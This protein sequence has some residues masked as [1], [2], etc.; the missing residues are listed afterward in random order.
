MDTKLIVRYAI[1]ETM[2][3]VIMGIA[4]FWS[5]GQIN[6]WPAWASLAVMFIWTVATAVVIVRSNPAL[7]VER[8]GPRKGAKAWDT[9][10]LS[11]LGVAQLVRYVTAGLDQRY[12]WT[13]GFPFVA[14]FAALAACVLGYALVVWATASNAFFS[15]IVRIQ[16]E[17][18]H[19]V[20]TGGP[21]R[22]VR[23]PAYVG[24]IVYELAVSILLASWS[25]FIISILS[26]ILLILRTILEDRVLLTE[27]NGYK[28]YARRVRFRLFPGL[29]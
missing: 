8:L 14:Q 20:V 21:Y 19:M 25:A 17:R 4:L 29:W 13:G 26:T 18:G 11:L 10:I 15:Q 27:L 28:N 5:A 12:G 1:R 6:W 24:A 23:H 22:Y 2:G 7:L 3:L 16:A 9:V